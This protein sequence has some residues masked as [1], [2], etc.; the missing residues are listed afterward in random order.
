MWRDPALRT[1]LSRGTHFKVVPA[2]CEVLVDIKADVSKMCSNFSRFFVIE[3]LTPFCLRASFHI[4]LRNSLEQKRA[5]H[6]RDFIMPLM[7]FLLE[8]IMIYIDWKNGKEF[9]AQ[10]QGLPTGG[11][12]SDAIATR[13]TPPATSGDIEYGSVSPLN[14]ISQVL[15]P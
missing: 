13:R 8:H 11:S 10:C 5:K 12:F 1:L 2:P 6:I 9:Y 3:T 14:P 4:C 7:K 15:S